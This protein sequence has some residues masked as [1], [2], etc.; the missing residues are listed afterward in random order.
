MKNR[1]TRITVGGIVGLAVAASS[2]GANANAL[3]RVWTAAGKLQA[4]YRVPS[5]MT[6][7]A[8]QFYAPSIGTVSLE[9]VYILPSLPTG[10]TAN[11]PPEGTSDPGKATRTSWV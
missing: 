3:R 9:R 5:S 6:P 1:V 11:V 7:Y 2:L 8:L 4:T 10:D